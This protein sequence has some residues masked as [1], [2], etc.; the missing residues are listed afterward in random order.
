MTNPSS[1]T[2]ARDEQRLATYADALADAI[3]ATIGEWVRRSI[4]LHDGGANIAQTRIDR[5][6][7]EAT[8]HVG[9]RVRDLVGLD[10]ERQ[11]TNPLSVLRWAVRFPTEVL[12]EAG[13]APVARDGFAREHFPDDPYDLTPASFSDV[14]ER[15]HEPGLLWGA[16][17]AHV[18]LS[19]RREAGQA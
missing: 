5:A 2:S 19:R 13:V 10:I 14:D 8:E 6:A 1:D 12:L 4:A 3:E 7:N 9:R 18:H 15:L 17:K 16:A 11:S